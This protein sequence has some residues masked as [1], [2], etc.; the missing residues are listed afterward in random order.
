VKIAIRDQDAFIRAFAHLAEAFS[1]KTGHPV[2]VES[3]PIEEHYR[4]LFSGDH[5][6]H[7]TLTDW[8][9]EA[10]EREAVFPLPFELSTDQ[11]TSGLI[12][13]VTYQEN[14]M[15]LPF[16]DGP[17]VLHYRKDLFN[18]GV[19][20]YNYAQKTGRDL[21]PP[22]HWDEF[23]DIALYFTRPEQ[24]LWGTCFAMAPDGHNNVYDFTVQLWARGGE[25]VDETARRATF[26]S[27]AGQQ[28]LQFLWDCFHEYRIADPRGL[29]MNSVQSGQ[30]YASGRAAMMVNWVGFA[31]TAD[32]ETSAIRGKNKCRPVPLS[33]S[34]SRPSLNVFWTLTVR[35]PSEI[36]EAFLRFVAED[37]Q[38]LA[39]TRLGCNGV[40]LDTW[41][42]V[43]L[44]REFPNLGIIEE[45]HR[46]A[47]GL[48][49]T[50]AFPK[51]VEY[52]NE[53]IRATV[54]DRV[55]VNESLPQAA[56][57]ATRWWQSQ[58]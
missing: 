8:L 16:H 11:Y 46:G 3:F 17:Q 24:G 41:R 21:D 25:L 2:E 27:L 9:A 30:Y 22:N 15:A 28:G 6:L 35:E 36:T 34:G 43:M 26:D 4:Q 23:V 29:E 13:V 55:A 5:D 42:N 49:K 54:H 58:P 19:E 31:V 20:A 50:A 48:P 7:L 47:R 40:K 12:D 37:A 45:C 32:L 53:A 57:L 1:A 52:L 44:Y 51:I 33:P 38:D 14:A 39:V 10:V 18:D 56:E